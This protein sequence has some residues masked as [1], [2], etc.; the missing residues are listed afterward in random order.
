MFLEINTYAN[1]VHYLVNAQGIKI[2]LRRWTLFYLMQCFRPFSN[3]AQVGFRVQSS[4]ANV[5]LLRIHR[6]LQ[7]PLN[8]FEI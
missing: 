3:N 7:V 1:V 5:L 2:N 4:P 6:L 8:T